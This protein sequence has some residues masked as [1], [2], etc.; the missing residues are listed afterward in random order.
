MRDFEMRTGGSSILGF[1]DDPREMWVDGTFR[2]LAERL[3][4]LG[5]LKIES[6]GQRTGRA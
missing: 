5:H 2:E 6:L 1:H 3:C 4:A